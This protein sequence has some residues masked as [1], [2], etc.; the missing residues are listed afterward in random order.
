MQ[1]LTRPAQGKAAEEGQDG[2]NMLLE[3]KKVSSDHETF[4][5]PQ[6]SNST[7]LQ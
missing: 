4:D 3:R 6:L 5:S 1:K 2:C 7:A